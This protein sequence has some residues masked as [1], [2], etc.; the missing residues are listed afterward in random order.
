MTGS[1]LYNPIFDRSPHAFLVGFSIHKLREKIM[2]APVLVSKSSMPIKISVDEAS[3][4]KVSIAG[5][6]I[7]DRVRSIEFHASVGEITYAKISLDVYLNEIDI[8][9]SAFVE[10]SREKNE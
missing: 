1:L 5:I 9:A 6:D 3:R 2:I 7:S 4:G 10:V 8:D